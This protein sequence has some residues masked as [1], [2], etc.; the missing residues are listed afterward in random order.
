MSVPLTKYVPLSLREEKIETYALRP[1]AVVPFPVT[2]KVQGP[3]A[4]SRDTFFGVSK[5]ATQPV[6][7]EPPS[8]DPKDWMS[9]SHMQ[10][11]GLTA[12]P[13]SKSMQLARA[14]SQRASNG[15][16]LNSF[17]PLDRS[18]MSQ[19][20]VAL[21]EPDRQWYIRPATSSAS[22]QKTKSDVVIAYPVQP[23]HQQYE[24]LSLRQ[25]QPCSIDRT[26][27]ARDKQN[28]MENKKAMTASHFSLSQGKSEANC[29]TTV[30]KKP[31]PTWAPKV[32]NRAPDIAPKHCVAQLQAA[33]AEEARPKAMSAADVG[34]RK[35]ESSVPMLTKFNNPQF[36]YYSV[37]R[38]ETAASLPQWNVFA[39]KR[40]ESG[41]KF[42]SNVNL[43]SSALNPATYVS[44]TKS[45]FKG[46]Y[47]K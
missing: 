29:Y 31:L 19:T 14:A 36:D 43:G 28:N 47:Y 33:S 17:G 45:E 23:T 3:P 1:A 11:P 8:Y 22:A 26:K 7:S 27:N 30:A 40:G 4:V 9:V 46:I 39:Q 20:T 38:T 16:P 37:P 44:H 42:D 21:R 41:S 18:M 10:F 25:F 2:A 34:R 32:K 35:A 6:T 15:I 12:A 24:A 5:P 13:L